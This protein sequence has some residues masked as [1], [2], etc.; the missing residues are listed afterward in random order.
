MTKLF[1]L[2]LFLSFS[3]GYSQESG[4][5]TKDGTVTRGDLAAT[6]YAKD[7]TANAFFIHENGYSRFEDGHDYNILNNYIAKIKILN[8]EGYDHAN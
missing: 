6:V 7:S 2:L 4:L 8:K 5:N 1:S 3:V